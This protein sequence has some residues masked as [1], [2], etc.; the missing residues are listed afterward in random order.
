LGRIIQSP[1]GGPLEEVKRKVGL[2]IGRLKRAIRSSGGGEKTKAG[3][4]KKKGN[5]LFGFLE[6][7][8]KRSDRN[9]K[10]A[11]TKEKKRGARLREQPRS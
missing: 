9:T 3:G 5:R 10:S 2:I 7:N 1:K 8:G 6:K 4:R 11:G